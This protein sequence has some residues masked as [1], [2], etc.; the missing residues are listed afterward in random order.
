MSRITGRLSY[1]VALNLGIGTLGAVTQYLL[2]GEGPQELRDYFFPKTGNKNPDGT[3]ARI[4]FPSYVKDEFGFAR[5]PIDT[6][7]HK[8]HPSFSMVAE[9]LNNKDFYGNEIFNPEDPWT[10]VAEQVAAHIGKGFVPYAVQNQQQVANAGGSVAAR[11]APFVGVT[12]A[13]GDI[14][15]S[16]FQNYVRDKYF[17]GHPTASKSPEKAEASKAL[18]QA[19]Q[20]VRAG[21]NP[22]LSGFTPADRAK[23][24][25]Y[26]HEKPEQYIEKQFAGLNLQQKLAAY[27]RASAAE[28]QQYQLRQGLLR[29]KW[30]KEIEA[31]QDEDQRAELRARVRAIIDAK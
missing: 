22:D 20:A 1:L 24:A 29:S 13:P 23:I 3:D 2:T 4:S 12:P 17:A 9:L 10:K 16:D 26:A 15:H 27:D 7:E 21:Q 6:V 5:H 25:K 28:R 11:V 31:I 19:V 14:T 18:T 8:L 30:A